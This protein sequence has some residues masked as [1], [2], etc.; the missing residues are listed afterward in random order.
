M[1]RWRKLG[2]YAETL[3]PAMSLEV[4]QLPHQPG[5]R[6]V[7]LPFPGGPRPGHGRVSLVMHRPAAPSATGTWSGLL[8]DEWSEVIPNEAELTGIAYHYDDPG[9]EAPQAL[10]IAVPPDGKATW[11]LET[12]SDVLHETLELAKLRA[13]DSELVGGLAQLLPAIHLAANHM[14]DTISV[15]FRAARLSD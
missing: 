2:L 14:G 7:G 12:L 11:D 8:V 1:A 13:V 9:A 5:E 4:A 6:W 10:L 3:G 15:D